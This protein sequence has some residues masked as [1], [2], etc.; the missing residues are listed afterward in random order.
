MF[1]LAPRGSRNRRALADAPHSTASTALDLQRAAGD[2]WRLMTSAAQTAV[3]KRPSYSSTGVSATASREEIQ[4]LLARPDLSITN[5]EWVALGGR[6]SRLYFRIE[7]RLYKIRRHAQEPR[8]E[9]QTPPSG[10]RPPAEERDRRRRGG[11]LRRRRDPRGVPG[12]ERRQRHGGRGAP[13]PRGW[14]EP[15]R[16]PGARAGGDGPGTRLPDRSRP[17]IQALRAGTQPRRPKR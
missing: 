2:R 16:D 13:S 5:V 10:R 11:S 1:Y 17:E 6:N 8:Q 3:R 14:L 15:A 4:T 12:D 7:R 9:V